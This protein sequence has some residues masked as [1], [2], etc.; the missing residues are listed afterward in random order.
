MYLLEGCVGNVESAVNAYKGGADRLE[1]CSN[2]IIGGTTPSVSLLAQ[3][4]ERVSI[5][6][7]PLIRPRFGDFLYNEEEVRE[8][9]DT[10]KELKAAGADGIVIGTLTPEGRLDMDVMRRLIDAG[11]GLPVTLHRAFDMTRDPYE[12][13]E[14]AIAL[15]ADTILTSGQKDACLEGIHLYKE[16]TERAQGRISIMAG[17][18]INP[19]AIRTLINETDI[20][21][22]HMSGKAVAESRM[23]YRNP[24]VNMGLKGLSEYEKWVSK[25]ENFKKARE[26][27]NGGK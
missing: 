17:G 4:K 22:F 27:L 16:L 15:G 5:P 9:E 18:G 24:D 23:E 25:E 12:A 3:S 26:V 6:I 20:K 13:L 8:M 7:R 14:D 19:D 21:A 2:L 11:A 10:I 1:L